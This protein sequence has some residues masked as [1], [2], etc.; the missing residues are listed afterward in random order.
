MDLI[1][2][3]DLFGV[4]VFAISGAL[5]A[6]EQRYDIMGVLFIAFITAVGG[7]IMRDVVLGATPVACMRDIN[8]PLT[9]FAGALL[10]VAFKPRFIRLRKTLTFFDAIGIGVFTIIGLEK[11]M[12][13]EIVLPMKIVLGMMTAVG[14]GL[15]RD[16][17][18][19]VTPLIFHK[20]VYASACLLG[21][22]VFV[23]TYNYMPHS[24]VTLLSASVIFTVRI[25]AVRK[26][27]ALKNFG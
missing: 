3:L 8:Y 14:G 10:A 19:N 26:G 7:G 16:V 12:A 22:I 4:L 21:G 18:C 24:I 11:S 27:W 25:L 23:S 13:F 20:E 9:I 2:M 5:M 1:Y 17:L 6:M 15:L